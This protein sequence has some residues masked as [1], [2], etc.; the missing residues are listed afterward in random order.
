MKNHT[1]NQILIKSCWRTARVTLPLAI[2][3]VALVL[4]TAVAQG[5]S[6]TY[7]ALYSFAGAPDAAATQWGLALD[8][9][10]NLYGTSPQGGAFGHGTVFK[11]DSTGRETILHSFSGTG[12]DGVTPDAGVIL[13]A[14]GNLYGSTTA[15]GN[16]SCGC[17][18]IFKLDPAGTETILHTF[19]GTGG[20]G[21]RP[22]G[23]LVLDAQGNLYGT[24]SSGGAGFGG[25]AFKLTMSGVETVLH[26]FAC[27]ATGSPSGLLR[28]AAGNFFGATASGGTGHGQGCGN[29]GCGTLFELT[30]NGNLIVL[31]SFDPSV[32]DGGIPNRR[33]VMDAQGNLYGTTYL[34][35]HPFRTRPIGSGIVFKVDPHGNETILHIFCPLGHDTKPSCPDGAWPKGG[36]IMDSVGNLYGTT[37]SGGAHSGNGT[38]FRVDPAGNETVPYSF[39]KSN[40]HGYS[41]ITNLVIDGQGNFYGTASRG[42]T[43]DIGVV[44][45]MLTPAAATT[46]TISSTPNP[47]IF[48]ETVTFTAVVTSNTGAPPDGETVSFL[49]GKVVMGT[50]TTSGGSASFSISTLAVGRRTI[51]ARYEG[52]PHLIS[53]SNTEIQ[54]VKSP[55]L[56]AQ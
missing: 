56:Q 16:N 42:G 25:I 41:P 40:G 43:N 24:A 15:G 7:Q 39:A 21:M 44:F 1:Q 35:G 54:V 52:D 20:D 9:E 32:G 12:G 30:K 53:S 4:S 45:G 11:L 27:C 6:Y 48:G 55:P 10:G 2:M 37:F 8:T 36:L 51:T 23:D 26:S 46:T 19:T 13:D 3:F 5:Q 33:L 49:N 29:F 18:I 31:H 50:G 22:S 14:Q 47:S 28:D 34:G 17:G 38:I